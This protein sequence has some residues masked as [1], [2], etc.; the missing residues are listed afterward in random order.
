MSI[1]EEKIRKNRDHYDAREPEEGHFERFA[2]RL[3]ER[4]HEKK[5]RRKGFR[6]LR[7]AAAVLLIAGISGILLY[8]Y[9]GRSSQVAAN[10]VVQELSTVKDHYN[11]L[12]DR[13][14]GQI[15]ACAPTGEEAN[16]IN[17]L[18]KEQLQKLDEDAR[19]LEEELE[20][21]GS[22]ERVYGALVSNYRTR[23][24]ILDNIINQI[25]QL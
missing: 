20:N 16:K 2:D 22:N 14:L 21:D 8:Q 17:G 5:E 1:L 4:F 9:A 13:K 24:K 7:Y 10:P 15:N 25:C 11:R 19:N 3:D 23:I 18:A 6:I 12:A